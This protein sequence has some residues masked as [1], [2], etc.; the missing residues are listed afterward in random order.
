MQEELVN[1]SQMRPCLLKY[2]LIFFRVI[3]RPRRIYAGSKR[4]EQIDLN[5][6]FGR[7]N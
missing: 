7:N 6:W 3:S 1:N 5:L 2:G 4:A